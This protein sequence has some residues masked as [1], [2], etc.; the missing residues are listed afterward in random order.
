LPGPV[1]EDE[2][3]KNMT[4]TPVEDNETLCSVWNSRQ[5][6]TV[7]VRV[8]YQKLQQSGCKIYTISRIEELE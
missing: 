1:L 3:R 8:S 4:L 6:K 2:G 7:D 5:E